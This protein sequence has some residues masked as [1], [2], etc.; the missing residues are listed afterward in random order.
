M[1]ITRNH[2]EATHWLRRAGIALMLALLMLVGSAVASDAG[3]LRAERAEAATIRG[4]ASWN[5][6]DVLLDGGETQGAAT[7][8][9]DA[10]LI[11]SPAIGTAAAIAGPLAVYVGA[12]CVSMVSVCAARAVAQGRWAGITFAPGSAWCWTY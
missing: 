1:T 10:M 9:I 6:L 3:P 2:E 11:C 7:G 8:A 12:V 5:Q 4:G